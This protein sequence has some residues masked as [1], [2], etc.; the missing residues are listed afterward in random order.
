MRKLQIFACRAFTHPQ[1]K[2]ALWKNIRGPSAEEAIDFQYQTATYK[3]WTCFFL[4]STFTL[5]QKFEPYWVS[6]SIH[7]CTRKTRPGDQDQLESVVQTWLTTL[8]RD[9]V[10]NENDFQIRY[11]TVDRQ[12]QSVI[13]DLFE[14]PDNLVLSPRAPNQK[15]WTVVIGPSMSIGGQVWKLITFFFT[16]DK[17]FPP[18][19]QLAHGKQQVRGPKVVKLP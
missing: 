15:N 18:E 1:F 17:C 14:I 16:S 9:L 11:P 8:R 7:Q 6:I 2:A 4:L 3:S 13:R 5:S 10:V 19:T 12:S